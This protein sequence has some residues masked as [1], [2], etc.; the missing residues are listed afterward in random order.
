MDFWPDFPAISLG[1]EFVAGGLG[2]IAGVF[3]GHPLDTLRIRQQH[4]TTGSAFSFLRNIVAGEGTLA[5]YRGM[6]APLVTVTLQNAVV[7]QTHE[8]I[9]RAIDAPATTTNPPSYTAVAVGGVIAGALQSLIIS[10]VE[11][12]KIRLQLQRKNEPQGSNMNF[13][14]GPVSVARSIVK[15][16]GLR[17]IFRGLNV[18][19]L[20][21]LH[22]YGVYFWTYEYMKEK[23]QPGCRKS[24]EESY[25]TTS[26]AGGLAGV[27][28][29]VSCYPLDFVKTRLQAQTQSSRVKYRGIVDCLCK[30][31]REEGYGVLWRGLGTTVSRAF[32]VNGVIFTAYKTALR[33]LFD[34]SNHRNVLS[35]KGN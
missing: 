35:D 25:K 31:A 10:P 2:G 3:S 1:R 30:S 32:L 13:H 8:V 29:W 27:S 11:L 5:L 16:E 23:L 15:E 17:G 24:G 18:T 20:R 6:G 9:L 28:S 34:N 21:D 7:F 26:M 33:C 12:V 19:L 22:S 4:S 14:R